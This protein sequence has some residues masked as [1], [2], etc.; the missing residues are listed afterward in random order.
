MLK[1]VL[2]ALMLYWPYRI[3]NPSMMPYCSDLLG[4]AAYEL[5]VG[6]DMLQEDEQHLAAV[7][8]SHHTMLRHMTGYH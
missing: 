5:S 3:L 1:R 7:Q 8:Q 4:S 2:P 6:S